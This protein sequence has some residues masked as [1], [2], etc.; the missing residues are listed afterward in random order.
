[1]EVSEF[2]RFVADN[3]P[4]TASMSFPYNS[5][6]LRTGLYTGCYLGVHRYRKMRYQ[7]LSR[8]YVALR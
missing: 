2:R 4:L 7:A 5:V 8:V 6:I 1:M 3:T